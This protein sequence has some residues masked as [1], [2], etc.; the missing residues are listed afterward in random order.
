MKKRK[1]TFVFLALF[2]LLL[3]YFIVFEKDRPTDDELEAT[4]N[5]V[6]LF[7]FETESIDALEFYQGT[8]VIALESRNGQWIITKPE[9]KEADTAKVETI[10]ND[11]KNLTAT[12]TMHPGDG[13]IMRLTNYGLDPI[14]K[15]IA[16]REQGKDEFTLI[17]IGDK[18]PLESE[19][20]ISLDD[21]QTVY[22]VQASIDS[23]ANTTFDD[24]KY[25]S[26]TPT[27]IPSNTPLP[28]HT[29][30]ELLETPQISEET[31]IIT[32]PQP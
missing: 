26:P 22:A 4:K 9:E 29:P 14:M 5:D 8:E 17:N 1:S 24:L 16:F 18:T 28:I 19:Y 7:T 12:S 15:K 3:L 20:Y 25:L 21:D 13:N 11:L 10:I 30:I 2:V 27:P 32:I 23:L 6:K 31:P